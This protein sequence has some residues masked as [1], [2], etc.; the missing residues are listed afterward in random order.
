MAPENG[1]GNGDKGKGDTGTM[2]RKPLTDK[3]RERI[4]TVAAQIA[5]RNL[6]REIWTVETAQ[7]YCQ[8]IHDDAET[9]T[10]FLDA[11]LYPIR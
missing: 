4:D 8:A 6:S 11:K 2:K 1:K 7:L 10:Q 9:Y 5:E 3:Q